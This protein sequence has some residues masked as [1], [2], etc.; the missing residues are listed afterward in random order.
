MLKNWKLTI[1]L[2]TNMIGDPP[3]LDSLL[4]EEMSFRLGINS[5][6]N[7]FT[8]ATKMADAKQVPIPICKKTINGYDIFQC[9]NPIYKSNHTYMVHHAKRFDCDKNAQILTESERKSLLTSSGPFKMRYAP[10]IVNC[11]DK[12]IYFFRGDR[13]E[14]NKLMKSIKYLGK[15]RNIGFGWI[16]KFEF[17]EQEENFSIF[18]KEGE[19]TYLMRTIPF[20]KDIQREVVNCVEFFG[21]CK[22]PYWH[23]DNQIRVLKPC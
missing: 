11:I 5:N 21:A 18:Y 3:Q 15:K 19:K 9:S 1:Y 2:L 20:D 16:D 14:V 23:A 10:E 12:I 17:E 13:S 4:I 6:G 22:P 7:K 8:K